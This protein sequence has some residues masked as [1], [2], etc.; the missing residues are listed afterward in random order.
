MEENLSSYLEGRYMYITQADLIRKAVRLLL[1]VFG[2]QQPMTVVA[3]TA[4][5][6]GSAEGRRCV[7][8]RIRKILLLHITA[9]C[10]HWIASNPC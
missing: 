1:G 5:L 10:S 3:D 8:G 4:A 2:W 7:R 9:S 6:G